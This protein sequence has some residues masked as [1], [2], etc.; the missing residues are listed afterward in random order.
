VKGKP[1][2]LRFCEEQ[3]SGNSLL[4]A[5]SYLMHEAGFGKV[6]EFLL[7]H[8]NLIVQ[9][10]SGVPLK[11]F[12]NASWN[13]RL[14]GPYL[15]PIDT[16]KKYWQADLAAESNRNAPAPL[17]FGFGYQWQPSRSSLIIA[18]RKETRLSRFEPGQ[19]DRA[20]TR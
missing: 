7:A 16:F 1:G 9:D 2:F 20:A 17:P 18:T 11:Y 3:G 5:A 13:I 12:E 15:G 19:P 4:K 8:S 6:R 14:C 10:D